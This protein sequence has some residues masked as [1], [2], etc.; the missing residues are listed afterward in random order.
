MTPRASDGFEQQ[1]H[2]GF[3]TC[4]YEIFYW[5]P[6]SPLILAPPLI[7]QKLDLAPSFPVLHRFLDFWK[8]SIDARLAGVRV[9]GG[10]HFRPLEITLSPDF[11]L[12]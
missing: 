7:I 4:L 12:H 9:E 10:A 11:R 1:V 5:L 8:R 6:D 3:Q 2:H